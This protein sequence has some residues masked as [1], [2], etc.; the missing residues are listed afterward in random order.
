[1][2]LYLPTVL[3]DYSNF[4]IDENSVYWPYTIILIS[5]TGNLHVYLERTVIRDT[6]VHQLY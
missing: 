4:K 6:R 1:M 5:N 3:H 2:L